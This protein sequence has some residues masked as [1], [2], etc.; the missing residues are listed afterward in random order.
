MDLES[1]EKINEF[2]L[3]GIW[4]DR[5]ILLN[6]PVDKVKERQVIADR[7]GSSDYK[8][9]SQVQKAYLAIA[10]ANKDSYLVLDGEKEIRDNVSTALK[11]LSL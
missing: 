9:F 10:D 3:D 11:W 1:V 8:F 5:V 7:I 2:A 6:L 4:P